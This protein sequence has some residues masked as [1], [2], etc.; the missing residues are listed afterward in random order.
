MPRNKRNLKKRCLYHVYNRGNRKKVVFRNIDDYEFFL[1]KLRVV[2]S[3]Y[4]LEIKAYCLMDNHYHLLI[5]T[6][7]DP[8]EL[9]KLMQRVSTSFSLYI[10]KKYNL[11]GHVF[12]G[13]FQS[14]FVGT[15]KYKKSLIR[16]FKKNPVKAGY[17]RVWHQYR[18]MYLADDL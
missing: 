7:S 5:R 8:E 3:Q 15:E 11:V 1:F 12:Q 2:A 4:S 6:G 17:A 16:Y 9:S 13:R 10:N 14:S 18:W